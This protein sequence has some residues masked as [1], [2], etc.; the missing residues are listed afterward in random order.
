MK[1]LILHGKH[2]DVYYDASTPEAR[3]KAALSIMNDHYTS[4]YYHNEGGEDD[5]S[6][7]EDII[8][9]KN[10]LAAYRFIHSRMDYEYEAIDEETLKQL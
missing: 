2:G 4:G 6:K 3:W 7:A 10:G 5:K 9:N 1:I 8:K